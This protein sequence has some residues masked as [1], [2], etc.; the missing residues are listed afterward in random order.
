M[1]N[2]SILKKLPF[3]LILSLASVLALSSC[4]HTNEHPNEHP[5]EHPTEHPNR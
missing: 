5:S 1:K 4:T 2:P 3:L